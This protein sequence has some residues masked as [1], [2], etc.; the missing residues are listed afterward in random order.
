MLHNE[1]PM[2]GKGRDRAMSLAIIL[3]NWHNAPDTLRCVD[4]VKSWPTLRPTIWVVDNGS[5]DD[6]VSQLRRCCPDDIRLLLSEHNLGFAGG[7]NLAL[8]QAMDAGATHLLLLNNDAAIGQADVLQLTATLDATPG[9][10]IVGPLL[11][12][13][14]PPHRLQSAGGRNVAWHV[15]THRR[16]LPQSRAPFAADYVPGTV[17]LVH[18]QVFETVGLL[19]ERYFFSVEIADLCQRARRRGF[20]CL[21]DPAATAYH[22][23]DRASAL[24]ETLYAY[25]SLRNRFLYVAKFY[26]PPVAWLLALY[27]SA[28]G[29]VSVVGASLRGHRKRARALRLALYHG[30]S[31]RFGNRNR[32]ILTQDRPDV[33]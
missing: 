6:S 15:A 4:A 30:L 25:Y 8:R 23:T 17:L 9:A 2:L 29:L 32:E 18:R 7:N 24:R 31:D 21:V 1:L 27:W 26:P 12:D 16:D 22:D 28:W 5:Q 10:G 3:L 20:A 14:S 19:D 13:P 11:R 33:Q